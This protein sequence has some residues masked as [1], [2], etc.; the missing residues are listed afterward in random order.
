MYVLIMERIALIIYFALIY[1]LQ[2][3]AIYE[4]LMEQIAIIIDFTYMLYN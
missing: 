1:A 2:K 3:R 4:L